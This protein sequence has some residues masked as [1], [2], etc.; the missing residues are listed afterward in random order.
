MQCR[1]CLAEKNLRDS[2]VLSEFLFRSMYD[3]MHRFWEIS[4][5]PDDKTRIHQK[6]PREKLLCEDCELELSKYERYAS[7]STIA[8]VRVG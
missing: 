3:P 5:N 7:L 1:L 2:H 6:G 4:T 8:W